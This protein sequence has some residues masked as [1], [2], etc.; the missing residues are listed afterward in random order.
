MQYINMKAVI[1]AA[2]LGNRLGALTKSTPKALVTVLGIPLLDHLMQF[3]SA[4]PV[5]SIAVVTGYQTKMLETFVQKK[6]PKVQLFY[7]PDY[8]LGSILTLQKALPFLN[9]SFLI[10]NVDHIYP[11]RLA[12]RL[13]FSLNAVG[14]VCDFDR[15]LGEDD[16]KIKKNPLGHVIR[17]DK[18]LTNFD[19]GYI[20]MTFCPKNCHETYW[21]AA[22]ETLSK[23]G[24][25]A[26]VEAILDTL[27]PS[28]PIKIFDASGIGWL[29]VDT[30]EDRTQA[31]ET[32]NNNPKF[33]N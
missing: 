5:Q 26:N 2:G 30:D 32:L 7:N 24:P 23:K 22:E 19:G 33:L 18:K 31:E 12:Q 8:S 13:D 20:G 6:F 4:T 28:N 16:M 14:A 21:G 17:I 9:E 15:K 29:E 27:A 3:L 11:K 25:K 10:C 1:L